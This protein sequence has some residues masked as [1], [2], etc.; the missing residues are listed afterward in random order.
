MYLG[1]K[2]RVSKMPHL[3]RW[4]VWLERKILTDSKRNSTGKK[5]ASTKSTFNSTEENLT[6]TPA[7]IKVCMEIEEQEN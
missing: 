4:F 7:E 3:F 5:E 6:I 2:R 1:K